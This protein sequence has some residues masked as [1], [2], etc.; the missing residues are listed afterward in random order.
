MTVSAP[1]RRARA[2][3][4]AVLVGAT[5]LTACSTGG[6]VTTGAEVSSSPTA[7]PAPTPTV[8]TPPPVVP[9][10][11]IASADLGTPAP[12]IPP[13]RLQVPA[14]GVDMPVQPVGVDA[15][16]AMELPVDP[17]IAGWY[18][19][20]P[21]A[22]STAGHTVISAHVD[23]PQYPIGPLARLRELAPGG[24]ITVV[25]AT[26][27]ARSYAVESVTYYPKTDLPVAE[28]FTRAGEPRLVL[29]TCGGPFDSTTGRYRDNVVAIASPA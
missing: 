13:V 6:G 17:A 16:Q 18:R 12:A 7:T 20:G 4:A 10:V 19:F 27:T 2:A 29:I 3:F 24:E 23:A 8:V 14:I 5:L 11:P 21:D 28:I 26:G 22:A 1:R 25:D 9:E 15:N